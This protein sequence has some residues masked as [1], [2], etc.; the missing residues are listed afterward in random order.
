MPTAAVPLTLLATSR[1]DQN[2]PHGL[3]RR[4]KEMSAR[5]PTLDLLDVHQTQVY[6]VYQR[7]SLQCLAGFLV[8]QLGGRELSKFVIHERQQSLCRARISILNP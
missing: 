3:R 1:F 2:T 7:R 4:V 8:G 6:V 5:V